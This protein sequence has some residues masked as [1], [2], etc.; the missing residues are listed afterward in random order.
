M[1]LYDEINERFVDFLIKTSRSKTF[2]SQWPFSLGQYTNLSRVF[3]IGKSE[4]RDKLELR[5]KPAV[6]P[7]RTDR[8]IHPNSEGKIKALSFKS[9]WQMCQR[10]VRHEG[11]LPKLVQRVKIVK[12]LT[13]TNQNCSNCEESSSWATKGTG[14]ELW[15]PVNTQQLKH[16]NDRC[17]SDQRF[18]GAEKRGSWSWGTVRS[19]PFWAIQPTLIQFIRNLF[20]SCRR[21]QRVL[22]CAIIEIK[23]LYCEKELIRQKDE[24]GQSDNYLI[25]FFD[26]ANRS[27]ILDKKQHQSKNKENRRTSSLVS[28]SAVFHRILFPFEFCGAIISAWSRSCPKHKLRKCFPNFLGTLPASHMS[29]KSELFTRIGINGFFFRIFSSQF[30]LW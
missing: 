22:F 21:N 18:L 4:N 10:T 11:Y 6:A 1:E 24:M 27:K 2:L 8:V 5:Q 25:F 30:L 12:N 29:I 15:L 17:F 19:L 23:E 20:V 14:L 13:A 28:L 3:W 16:S 26:D 9:K 7:L